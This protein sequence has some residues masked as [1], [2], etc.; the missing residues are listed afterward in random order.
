MLHPIME[1]VGEKEVFSYRLSHLNL[2]GADTGQCLRP[3]GV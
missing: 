2:N 3:A 1:R